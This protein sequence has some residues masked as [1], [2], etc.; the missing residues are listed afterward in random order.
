MFY[1]MMIIIIKMNLLLYRIMIAKNKKAGTH[2]G[3]RIYIYEIISRIH[4]AFGGMFCRHPLAS[5]D[6]YAS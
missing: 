1:L 4:M 6:T 5:H 3:F 2:P